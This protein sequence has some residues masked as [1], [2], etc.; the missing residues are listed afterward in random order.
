VNDPLRAL[1]YRKNSVEQKN[2]P[3]STMIIQSDED[4][5]YALGILKQVVR[6]RF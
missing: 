2:T 6:L 1:T 5:D 3:E 4:V